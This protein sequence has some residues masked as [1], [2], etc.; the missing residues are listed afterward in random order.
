MINYFDQTDARLAGIKISSDLPLD[1]DFLKLHGDLMLTFESENYPFFDAT[2]SF[3][4]NCMIGNFLDVGLGVSLYHLFPVNDQPDQADDR[5]EE[6][7]Y[8]NGN[9]NFYTLEEQSLMARF[10]FDPKA[11]FDSNCSV[12]KI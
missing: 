6:H 3:V 2:P 8:K 5:S 12:K 9:G 10:T 7:V 11:L 4:G 1:G